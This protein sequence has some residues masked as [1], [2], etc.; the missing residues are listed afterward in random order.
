VKFV[1]DLRG[2][3]GGIPRPPLLPLTETAKTAITKITE[4]L[5]PAA[6]ANKA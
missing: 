4:S 3:R 6:V 2:Y 5:E 1:M